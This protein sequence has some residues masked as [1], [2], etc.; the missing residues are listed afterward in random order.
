MF[1]WDIVSKI[2]AWTFG[3]LRNPIFKAQERR[4]ELDEI[5]YKF[6]DK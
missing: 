3:S 4:V 5:Q 6:I 2:R 1:S